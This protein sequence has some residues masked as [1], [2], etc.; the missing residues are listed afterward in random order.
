[1]GAI[2]ANQKYEATVVKAGMEESQSK[3]TLGI[4]LTFSVKT[5][6]G[7]LAY[8]DHTM[9]VTPNTRDRVLEN[10][11]TLGLNKERVFEPGVLDNL[12]DHLQGAVCS[13]TTKLD[14]YRGEER[15]IVQWINPTKPPVSEDAATR[16]FGLLKGDPQPP[17][18]L[19]R[20]ASGAPALPGSKPLF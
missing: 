4:S 19:P 11:Q 2:V 8:I 20:S 7:G 16:M 18:S 5:E 17:V 10:L 1:M 6:D 12:T 13:I 3:G 9:W 15:V 14:E